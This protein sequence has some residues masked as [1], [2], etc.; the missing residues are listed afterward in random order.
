MAKKTMGKVLIQSRERLNLEINSHVDF[1]ISQFLC[2]DYVDTPISQR[3]YPELI[4]KPETG[5]FLFMNNS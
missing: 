4:K 2:L 5:N 1:N 3:A